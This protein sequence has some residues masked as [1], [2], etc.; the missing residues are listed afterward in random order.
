MPI[1]SSGS[2]TAAG[3]DHDIKVYADAGHGFLNDHVPAELPFWVKLVA[4][5]AA[6]RY[7]EPSASDAR[8]RIIAFLRRHLAEQPT[9]STG[10]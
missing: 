8:R 1:A 5:F 4:K 9:Q 3:I 10:R 2:L 6:A 7:D